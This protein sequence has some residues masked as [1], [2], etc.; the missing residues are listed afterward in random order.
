MKI[1]SVKHAVPDRRVTNDAVVEAIRERSRATLTAPELAA[2]ESRLRTHLAL[3]GTQ[4]RYVAG[5]ADG[6]DGREPIDYLQDAGERAM[7]EAGI[8]PTDVDFLVYAG[9]GR[10]WIEPAMA[11]LVQHRLGLVNATCFDV[12]DACAS[13]LR[14]LQVTHSFMRNGAY[15]C[16]MI[17]NC[18]IG[19]RRF[20]DLDFTSGG[21]MDVDDRLATFTIGEAA[22]AT[23]ITADHPTDDFYFLFKNFGQHYDLCMIPVDQGLKF[24]SRSQKLISTTVKEIIDAFNDDPNL[25]NATYDICFGHTASEKAN[26]V[27]ARRCHLPREIDFITHPAFGNT[28]AA[29][30]PLG[31][32]VAI[33][34]GRWRRG[35]HTLCIM[36]SAGITVGFARF[37][38]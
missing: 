24:Y 25:T 6:P 12:L 31:M 10:S 2:L 26:Q 16:A 3:A 9:I 29:S 17:V 18:E 32:S 15:R 30:L 34:Q 20:A 1:L 11:N 27:I 38:F 5:G 37:T 4:V 13:W 7:H 14:A 36:G 28:A 21:D 35:D 19:L 33:E 23:V 22:T 8:L